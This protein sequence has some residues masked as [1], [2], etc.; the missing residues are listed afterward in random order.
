MDARKQL[1]NSLTQK[2]ASTIEE[3]LRNFDLILESAEMREKEKELLELS[4]AQQEYLLFSSSISKFKSFLY[5]FRV[6][7]F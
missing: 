4:A 5:Y 7:K 3:S 6:R 1:L 2:N